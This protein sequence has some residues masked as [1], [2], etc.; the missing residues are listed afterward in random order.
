MSALS[1]SPRISFPNKPN[2]FFFMLFFASRN[3]VVSPSLRRD[4]P[5][6]TR[7]RT[8]TLTLTLTY[9]SALEDPFAEMVIFSF[10]SFFCSHLG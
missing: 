6:L 10:F 7:T 3:E 9:V 5:M 1:E 4:L 2:L 8:R